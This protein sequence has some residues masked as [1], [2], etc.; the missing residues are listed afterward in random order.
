MIPQIAERCPTCSNGW[1]RL[2]VYRYWDGTPR[3]RYVCLAGHSV[4]VPRL[5]ADEARAAMQPRRRR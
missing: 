4:W 2:E 3:S 1:I 5:T